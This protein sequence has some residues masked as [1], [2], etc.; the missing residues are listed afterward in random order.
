MR[1][2]RDLVDLWTS[3]YTTQKSKCDIFHVALFDPPTH[4]AFLAPLVL[5]SMFTMFV[6]H[7]YLRALI[8]LGSFW[9]IQPQTDGTNAL[10]KCAANKC[11][12]Y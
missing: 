8:L 4:F 6:F 3:Y 7:G 10:L 1:K 11:Y 5:A 12:E 2:Q 9:L